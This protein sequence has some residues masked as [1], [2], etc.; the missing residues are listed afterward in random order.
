MILG[1]Q[2]I[3]FAGAWGAER[4]R[5]CRFGYGNAYETCV[6]AVN[7]SRKHGTVTCLILEDSQLLASAKHLGDVLDQSCL[8]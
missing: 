8:P 1:Q 3:E 4:R 7:H 6:V 2:G 5:L